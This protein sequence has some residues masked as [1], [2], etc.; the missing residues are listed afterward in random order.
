MGRVSKRYQSII[1]F[2]Q[3][4]RFR[5]G[6]R[7]ENETKEKSLEMIREREIGLNGIEVERIILHHLL[8]LR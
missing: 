4:K 5:K 6:M 2:R 7:K 3:A 1:V 8:R